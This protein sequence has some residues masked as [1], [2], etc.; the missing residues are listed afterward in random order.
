[1]SLGEGKGL[2]VW[3]GAFWGKNG[4]ND[5]VIIVPSYKMLS[6]NGEAE[7]KKIKLCGVYCKN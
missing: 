7:L 6:T 2:I 5:H 3:V 1:V 4:L